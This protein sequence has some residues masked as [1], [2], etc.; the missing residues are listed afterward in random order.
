M[1]ETMLSYET[2]VLRRTTLFRIPQDGILLSYRREN[3]K[4]YTALTGWAL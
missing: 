3:F 1:M 2:S 4:S